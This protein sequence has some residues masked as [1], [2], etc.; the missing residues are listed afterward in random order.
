MATLPNNGPYHSE[1]NDVKATKELCGCG[2]YPLRTKFKGPAE[3]SDEGPLNG[4]DL[5]D[6]VLYFF[7][8]N[9]FFQ[10]YTV[11][12]AADRTLLYLTLYVHELLRICQGKA[13]DEAKRS[14]LEH[15][16]RSFQ[17]PGDKGF[18]L[19]G[20]LHKPKDSEEADEWKAYMKQCR[21][22]LQSRVLDLIYQH[23][24]PEKHPDK[25]WS[26]FCKRKFLGKQL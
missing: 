8:A 26:M 3:Q 9:M 13:I 6:E 25:Y 1:L 20:F 12:G 19:T 24:T 22:E 17:H 14:L 7:K 11:R 15:K 4:K 5:L 23:P 21:D 16:Q 18:P 10:Q 2:V